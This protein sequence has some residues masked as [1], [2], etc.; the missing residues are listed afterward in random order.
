MTGGVYTRF[1]DI[2]V[3]TKFDFLYNK[4]NASSLQ[5]DI[6]KYFSELMQKLEG[7]AKMGIREFVLKKY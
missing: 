6:Y 1:T 2:V 7:I 5:M 3:Y 4:K